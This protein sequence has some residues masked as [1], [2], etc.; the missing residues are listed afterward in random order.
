MWPLE[1][2]SHTFCKVYKQPFT[3]VINPS[4]IVI[5][6]ADLLLYFSRGSMHLIRRPKE[7]SPGTV[8]T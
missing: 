4:F 7:S 3:W 8:L 6:K 2:C 5:A 1:A